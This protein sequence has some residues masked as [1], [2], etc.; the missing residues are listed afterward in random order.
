MAVTQTQTRRMGLVYLPTLRVGHEGSIHRQSYDNPM[1]RVWEISTPNLSSHSE[2]HGSTLA[3]ASTREQKHG[4][5][6]YLWRFGTDPM[7]WMSLLY[8]DVFL[9]FKPAELD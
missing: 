4:G 9:S 2:I 6:R 7:V 8:S 1:G 3:T 5:N